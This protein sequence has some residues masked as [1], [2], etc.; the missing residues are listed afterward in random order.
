MNT[1]RSVVFLV[2]IGFV[3]GAVGEDPSCDTTCD[4]LG[5]CGPKSTWWVSA[6]AMFLDRSQNYSGVMVVD[7]ANQSAPV[8]TGRDLEFLPVAGPRFAL[9]TCL[10]RGLQAEL[11]YFGLHDWTAQSSVTGN[12]NLSLPGDI[13]TATQDFFAADAMNVNYGSRLQNVEANLWIPATGFEWMTGFRHFS[14][15][16]DLTISS[17]DSDT[18]QSSYAI[19]T[20]NQLFGGQIGVRKSWSYQALT[21]RPEL[22]FGVLGNSDNQRSLLQDLDNSI[23]LRNTAESSSNLST[24]SEIRL[25]S[26][27]RISE[28]FRVDFG[29]QFLWVT[30]LALAPNQLDFTDSATSGQFL[31]DGHSVFFQGANVGLTWTR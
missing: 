23:T 16:E 24:L 12:N 27:Y 2:I 26:D 15:I 18:F 3:E 6:E 11:V 10:G 7:D 5:T 31:S 13:A 19:D 22:K 4:S 29:Y 21:F 25:A 1:L 8:L 20:N 30:G 17:F 9:G 28:H 14:L